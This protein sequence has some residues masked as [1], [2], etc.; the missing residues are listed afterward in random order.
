MEFLPVAGA[1]MNAPR[2]VASA[3]DLVKRL[4]SRKD[5]DAEVEALAGL[6]SQNAQAIEVLA[7]D[8]H[9]NARKVVLL[10][11]GLGVAVV[12][13]IATLSVAIFL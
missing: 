3:M 13:N 4:R 2:A 10:T 9:A 7:R 12:V 1:L 8:L 11:W 6:V 5:R